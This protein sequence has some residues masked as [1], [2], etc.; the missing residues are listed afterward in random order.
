MN[1]LAWLTLSNITGLR[2]S[3][4]VLSLLVLDIKIIIPC[5]IVN[6]CLSVK[7]F[8][9][10][11]LISDPSLRP[12]SQ[13]LSLFHPKICQD[14]KYCLNSVYIWGYKS[15]IC[16]KNDGNLPQKVDEYKFL[17]N[18]WTSK[19]LSCRSE[20]FI[21]SLLGI[22]I[23]LCICLLFSIRQNKSCFS[24]SVYLKAPRALVKYS[25]SN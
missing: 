4:I 22:L 21:L 5:F 2:L 11:S 12:F 23:T 14:D 13:S 16:I 24:P 7:S 1:Q 10:N 25:F 9:W 15:W 20:I 18:L 19:S 17:L 3:I 8:F 6:H